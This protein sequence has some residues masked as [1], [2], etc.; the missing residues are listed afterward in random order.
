MQSSALSR[1]ASPTAM[2]GGVLWMVGA[3]IVALLPEGC[4]APDCNLPVRTMRDSRAAAPVFV[5]ALVAVAV[6]V[7]AAVQLAQRTGRFGRIGRTG[8]GASMGG[9]ALLTIAMLAQ[10]IFFGGDFPYMPMVVLPGVLA[11]SIGFVLVAVA[12]ARAG[13][14]PRWAGGILVIG[15]LALLGSNNQNQQALLMIPFGVAWV[16][17]AS[18][19]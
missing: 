13:V 4:I 17:W 1:W 9:V 18:R 6:G 3:V 11:A 7:G 10:A 15:A 2:L 19:C 12:L 8:L 5:A 16:R 14:L